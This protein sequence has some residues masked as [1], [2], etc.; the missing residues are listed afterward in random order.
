MEW[1]TGE[2][3]LFA[4]GYTPQ[5]G[6]H[7]CDGSLLQINSYQ[8]LYSLIGTTYGGDGKTTFAL[9]DL[10]GRAVIGQGI[11]PISG[12]TRDVGTAGGAETVAL[13]VNNLPAHIHTITNPT[14]ITFTADLQV[15]SGNANTLDVTQAKA[16]ASA[17]SGGTAILSTSPANA[18]I[19]GALTN[20]TGVFP[21]QTDV[22]GSSTPLS[23]MQPYMTLNYC[24]AL[25][26]IYPPQA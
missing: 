13:S 9:P 4:F 18:T 19:K 22:A 8:A 12:V 3:R 6:W 7:A 16:V 1:Y 23:I 20:V 14:T 26:G 15:F 5:G 11:S 21:A 17:T 2:I 24:I 25:T 10:R